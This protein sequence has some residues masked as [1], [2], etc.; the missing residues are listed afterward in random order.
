[1]VT[2][3]KLEDMGG[4]FQGR[5]RGEAL[6]SIALG[7]GIAAVVCGCSPGPTVPVCDD[8]PM[9]RP[10]EDGCG[11][12][13]SAS[14]GDD[15]NPGSRAEP[16]KTFSRALELADMGS[17]RVYA[18]AETFDETLGFYGTSIWGGFDCANGWRHLG[19]SAKTV[20]APA[21]PV[22]QVISFGGQGITFAN[23]RI[24]APDGSDVDP[25]QKGSIGIATLRGVQLKL[26]ASE[27]ITGR[28][29]KPGGS[30]I[31]IYLR[32]GSEIEVVDSR[33]VAGDGA[34]GEP[35][36]AAE[37]AA[38]ADGVSGHPGADACTVDATAGTP[39]VTT[40]CDDGT[41]TSGEGGLGLA[42]RG[43][44]GGNGEPLPDPNPTGAGAGGVGQQGGV[45]CSDGQRGLDGAVGMQG[46]GARAPGVVVWGRTLGKGQDGQF[47]RPGQGG[48]GGGGSRGGSVACGAGPAGGAFGGSGGS[49]GCGGK[50]G[51]GG[52][53]GGA[54][55]GIATRGAKVRARGSLIETGRGG[56]GGAGGPG[57]P[58]G[59]GAPG[60]EG[61]R[62]V[63]GTLPGCR[64]G[65][66][67]KGG[68]GGG[69]GGGLG[70]HSVG[71]AY[72]GSEEVTREDVE[73]TFVLGTAGTGGPGGDPDAPESAGDDGV[74]AEFLPF[75]ATDP[76]DPEPQVKE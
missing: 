18:C 11:I 67:G 5:R 29:G 51:K 7:C 24:V 41:S 64:G 19:A 1:M 70:G 53:A 59:S 57:L 26:V 52:F 45:A 76:N 62:A 34:D 42:D 44:G 55:I 13:V 36:A 60:G 75:V 54:S 73:A 40:E 12:F 4:S 50:P 16:V 3:V 74:A 71:I 32:H 10:P 58:G 63:P 35:G 37:G 17:H 23:L 49:G 61:G 27:V 31:P 9:V 68:P 48:G 20:V 21:E 56:R 46:Q 28:G 38:A 69:G 66:G 8:D 39:A 15:A 6:V 25:V 14:L 47:G 22:P 33:I 65:D 2:N 43:S 30:S 72:L